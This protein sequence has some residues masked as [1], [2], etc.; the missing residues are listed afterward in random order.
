MTT[1]NYSVNETSK[2][3]KR[4]LTAAF[5]GVKFSVRLDKY[6]MGCSIDASWTDG[7]TDKQVKAILDRF[8]GQGFDGMTDCSYYCGDRMFK[9]ERVDFHSGYVRG[10]RKYSRAFMQTVAERV[11]REIPGVSAPEIHAEYGGF[12]TG[13]DL[14]VPYQFWGHWLQS[15]DGKEHLTACDLMSSKHILAHDSHEGEYLTRLIDKVMGAT[16]LKPTAEPVE[17][18]EYIDVQA[19]AR[20]G[21]A[22]FEAKMRKFEGHEVLAV[23]DAAII[24][25]EGGLQ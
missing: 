11:C 25:F 19:E 20:T 23:E 1:R 16:S 15:C 4:T 5:P 10:G 7:P 18:P 21:R 9:G 3:I 6:S 17:L 12:T 13:H 22:S 8:D 24:S 2:L 14:R